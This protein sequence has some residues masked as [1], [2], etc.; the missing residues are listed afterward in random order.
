[1]SWLDTKTGVRTRLIIVS[2]I[3]AVVLILIWLGFGNFKLGKQEIP[4]TPGV[5]ILFSVILAII[6]IAYWIVFNYQKR[7]D[8]RKNEAL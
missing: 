7:R 2:V 1:M 4:A 6:V 3:F 5:K 8:T